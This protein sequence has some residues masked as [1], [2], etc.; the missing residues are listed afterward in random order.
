MGNVP[1]LRQ[2]IILLQRAGN[3]FEV[4]KNSFLGLHFSFLFYFH[5]LSLTK[6]FV[7][8]LTGSAMSETCGKWGKESGFIFS[9]ACFVFSSLLRIE[10]FP[11]ICFKGWVGWIM[12]YY[13]YVIL[14]VNVW[15]FHIMSMF[16]S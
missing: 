9:Q 12:Q 3:C 5:L 10:V 16:C 6:H 11:P 7:M 13:R 8:C 4:E 15:N 2:R 1:S 14:F